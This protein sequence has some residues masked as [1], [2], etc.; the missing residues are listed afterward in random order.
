MDPKYIEQWTLKLNNLQLL[1]PMG[2]SEDA[3]VKY[4]AKEEAMLSSSNTTQFNR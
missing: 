4:V 3:I 2:L 1:K